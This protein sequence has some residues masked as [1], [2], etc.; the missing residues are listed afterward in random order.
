MNDRV[1]SYQNICNILTESVSKAKEKLA[2]LAP[3][4]A[5]SG[6][7]SASNS[8]TRSHGGVAYTA[9]EQQALKA[10]AR[11]VKQ[12]KQFANLLKQYKIEK[13]QQE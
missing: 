6:K 3:N 13:K 8:P 11:I 10:D 2:H 1:Q 4:A 12:K 9:A 7:K 5:A